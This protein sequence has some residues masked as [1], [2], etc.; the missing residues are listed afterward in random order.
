VLSNL[1]TSLIGTYRASNFGKHVHPHLCEFEYRFNCRF[2]LKSI[3][4][5]LVR[6]AQ[7]FFSRQMIP[8]T[9]ELVWLCS[10]ET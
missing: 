9:S 10:L 7:E 5:H 6:A 4:E 3:F 1:K 8:L 2:N